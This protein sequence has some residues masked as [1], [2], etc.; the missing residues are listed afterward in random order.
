MNMNGK[1]FWVPMVYG[2]I[3]YYPLA[4]HFLKLTENIARDFPNFKD[5]RKLED[6]LSSFN[7]VL[8]NIVT[9]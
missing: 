8:N 2:F 3:S 7:S 1:Y 4:E 9:K 6:S 5:M